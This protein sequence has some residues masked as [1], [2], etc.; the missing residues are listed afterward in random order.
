MAQDGR[1]GREERRRFHRFP[2]DADC[3]LDMGA[4]GQCRCDLLDLSLN[5]V[6]LRMPPEAPAPGAGAGPVDRAGLELRL[7]GEVRGDQVSMMMRVR[8]VWM[9]AGLLA[10]RF[11]SIDHE[12]FAALKAL[13]ADNLGDDRLLERELTQLDYWPGLSISPGD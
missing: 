13:V 3:S 6:L 2:F 9:D 11:E 7:E 5:G 12:S 4:A 8:A 1:A 10:C